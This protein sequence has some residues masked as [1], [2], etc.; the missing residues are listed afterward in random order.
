MKNAYPIT[1][2]LAIGMTACAADL[3]NHSL[4]DLPPAVKATIQRQA[5]DHSI[6]AIER[7][8]L[9]ERQVYHVR[10]EQPGIDKRVTIAVD[11]SLLKVSNFE[12]VNKAITASK[13]AG[14]G[15]WN[16]TK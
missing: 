1:Y 13:E 16:K 10:I 2:L 15:A 14:H 11:G 6:G 7:G 9:D 3:P 12:E 5:A 4:L 8:I